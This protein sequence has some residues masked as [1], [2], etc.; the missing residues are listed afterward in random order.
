MKDKGGNRIN[1]SRPA[2][3]AVCV[4]SVLSLA[5]VLGGTAG[6]GASAGDYVEATGETVREDV[7]PWPAYKRDALI[8][9]TFLVA[10]LPALFAVRCAL[11]PKPKEN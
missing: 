5:V 9:D 8:E 2:S 7:P 4:M 1:R 10:L 11:G 3:Y 6:A